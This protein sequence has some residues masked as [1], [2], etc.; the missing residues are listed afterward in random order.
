MTFQQLFVA[1]DDLMSALEPPKEGYK[2]NNHPEV[3]NLQKTARKPDNY[4][5]HDVYQRQTAICF[6]DYDKVEKCVNIGKRI[7]KFLKESDANNFDYDVAELD[8]LQTTEAKAVWWK[9]SMLEFATAAVIKHMGNKGITNY[10]LN[11][12]VAFMLALLVE[13]FIDSTRINADDDTIR[14]NNLNMLD[15]CRHIMN[16]VVNFV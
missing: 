6:F 5:L 14:I 13:R 9:T 12:H 2:F 7:K 11:L 16:Q 3:F 8:L 15:E 10:M 4:Y 1:G